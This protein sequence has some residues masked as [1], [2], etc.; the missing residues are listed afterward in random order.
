MAHSKKNEFSQTQVNLSSFAKVISHP[1]RLA[2][3]E[4]LAKK[5][6]CICGDI[7]ECLPLSQATVSQH[8]KELKEIGIIQGEINGP[9]VCYC[10]DKKKLDQYIVSFNDFAKKL[11]LKKRLT[12]KCE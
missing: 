4:L 6:S 3:L 1:A 7:V 11:N 9:R 2:I 5:N 12:N 8:L 10:L